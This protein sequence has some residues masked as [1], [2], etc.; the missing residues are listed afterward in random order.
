MQA[1]AGALFAAAL[2][3]LSGCLSLPD[4]TEAMAVANDPLITFAN[5]DGQ[6]SAMRGAAILS[7]LSSAREPSGDLLEKHLAFEQALDPANPLV[8]GN[9]LT[10]L[11]N[12]PDTYQA[13]FDAI[14]AARDHINLETYIFDDDEIGREFADLLLERQAAGVQ[15]NVIYDSVGGLLTPTAFFDRLRAGGISVLEFNP[16]NPLAANS[17]TWRLNNRDHRKQLIIDGHTAF[18][19]GINISGS[20]ASAPLGKRG[21]RQTGGSPQPA[22][23]WRDTHLRIE[24]PAVAEF[25]KLFLDTWTR[26]SGAP[27]A[28]EDYLPAIDKQGSEIVRAIGSTAESPASLIYLTLI[29]AI[30]HA[31]LRVHLTVAYFA[32]DPQLRKALVAAAARGVDVRLVL[33]SYS[34]SWP[35]F[36]VGRS[37]YAELLRGG[38]HIHERQGAVMHAKTATIDG[39]WSTI[40]STNLDWRSFLHNDEMNA[41]VLGRDFARQMEAMFADDLRHSDAIELRNWQRRSLL[42]RLQ[43]RFAR[44]GAYW[45]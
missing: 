18:T 11:Q 36:H 43:E 45:L 3:S 32:P 2:A 19:G 30:Q 31:A 10:L 33:P 25:Q 26:Q 17:R 20:Y 14:R 13:M 22:T 9:R 29:S 15:V 28:G 41:V 44:L 39:V 16:V 7:G 38:V 34:D 12:G 21:R 37:Y 5:A 27:L 1:R 24:G 42:L 23:G 4:A 6:V 35:V 8:L 40:G